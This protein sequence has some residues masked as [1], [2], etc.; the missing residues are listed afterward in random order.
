MDTQT[1]TIGK[2]GY[3]LTGNESRIQLP[4]MTIPPRINSIILTTKEKEML[5]NAQYEGLKRGVLLLSTLTYDWEALAWQAIGSAVNITNSQVFQSDSPESKKT[6]ERLSTSGDE[7][8]M[9]AAAKKIGS[10]L[11]KAWDKV[12]AKIRNDPWIERL[13]KV[14]KIGLSTLLAWIKKIILSKE[15]I[16]NLVPFY[17]ATKGL[18]D[19][20]KGVIETHGHRSTWD[21]LKSASPDIASGF[22]TVALN[23]FSQFVKVEGMRSAA[24]TAYTFA[25]T[26]TSVLLQIFT[27][28]ISSV[29]DF[30]TSIIEAV[31][32][33]AY[34]VFQAVTFGKATNLCRECVQERRLMTVSDFQT[35]CASSTYVGCVFFGAANYIGHFNITSVLSSETSIISSSSLLTSVAKVG[36]IQKSAC[37]Y[38]LNSNFDMKFCS[39]NEENQYGWAL[40]MMKGYGSDAPRSEFLTANA[41]SFT[42]FKHYGKKLWRKIK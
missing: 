14:L 22:P 4:G 18:I 37:S 29:V 28:G 13:V 3:N 41:S 1:A 39:K 30:V 17:A 31:S 6:M 40:Q 27:M 24:K 11:T 23:A 25:K 38:I 21:N 19:G 2:N 42:K 5:A 10:L 8:A 7:I 36:E 15:V 16:G 33:F 26:I 34:S 12:E 9:D 32:T 20:A 35:I